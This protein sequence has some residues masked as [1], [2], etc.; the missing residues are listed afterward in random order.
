MTYWFTSDEH[1]NHAATIFNFDIK[2]PF[3][4]VEHMNCTLINNHNDRVKGNDTVFHIGD[5]KMSKGGMTTQ[6]IKRHLNGTNIFIC[7]NH[8]KN[9]GNNSPIKHM[10]IETYGKK[11]LLVHKPEHASEIMSCDQSIDLAFVGHVHFAWKAKLRMVNVGV[12]QWGYRPIDAKQILKYYYREE[13]HLLA[14]IRT[15]WN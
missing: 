6:D 7:G 9:N 8:D 10:V 4:S 15:N 1:Y 5:F 2:R 3:V 14:G 13:E 12:D 11:V